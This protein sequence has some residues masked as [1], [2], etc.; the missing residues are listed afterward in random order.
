MIC[1]QS[2]GSIIYLT[3]GCVTDG[4]GLEVDQGPAVWD[5]WYKPCEVFKISPKIKHNAFWWET[6]DI[7]SIQHTLF[8]WELH[9]AHFKKRV[10]MKR[11]TGTGDLL[12]I[13]SLYLRQ[14][15][16]QIVICPSSSLVN[17]FHGQWSPVLQEP[18][19]VMGINIKKTK[20][21]WFHNLLKQYIFQLHLW[22]RRRG[23]C[24]NSVCLWFGAASGFQTH[25][26]R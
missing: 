24:R 1:C 19:T 10:K 17:H 23:L 16:K 26:R 14:M 15:G 13:S 12:K 11:Y 7:S 25:N 5:H 3:S 22:G 20:V 9:R 2:S 21:S 4:E 8:P 6:L 18:R